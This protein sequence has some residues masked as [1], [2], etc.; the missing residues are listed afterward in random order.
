MTDNEINQVSVH[1]IKFSNLLPDTSYF[2]RVFSVAENG[3]EVVSSEFSFITSA[4]P[5]T[6]A[7][8]ILAGPDPTN[9]ETGSATIEW[10]TDELSTSIIEFGERV[11]AGLIQYTGIIWVEADAA[12][13]T[14][15]KV[16]LTGLTPGTEYDYRVTSVDFSPLLNEVISRN[17]RF[18]TSMFNDTIAPVL[19]SGPIV[20]KTDKTAIFEWGTDEASDSFVF[21]KRKDKDKNFRKIGDDRKVTNHVVTVTNLIKGENYEFE[22]ASRDLAGNLMT[23]PTVLNTNDMNKVLALRKTSQVPGGFGVFFTNQFPDTRVLIIIEGPSVVQ[24]TSETITIQW[25]TDERSDSFVD[26]GLDESFG[27]IKGEVF[28]VT[29]HRV[30]LTNLQSA[31]VYNF[32]VSS[33]D[34]SNNG[35][36]T[37]GTSAV[38]TES[39]ADESPPVITIGP[40]I[41]S[42]TNDQATVLWETDEPADSRL[43]FGFTSDYERVLLST[44]DKT[45][46]FVTLTNLLPDTLYHLR[47]LSTDISDNGLTASADTT[48]RTAATADVIPP[49]IDSIRVAAITD[50]SATIIFIT[51]ELGD[52]FIEF[53]F[54]TDS[55]SYNIGSA[56]DV[57]E[58]ELTLTNL[59]PDTT[60]HFGVGS[61]DKS[62][63]E[64]AVSTLKRGLRKMS[65]P[66]SPQGIIGVA[67]SEQALINWSPNNEDDLAGYNL[68]K[69]EN[70][71]PFQLIETLLTDTF[72]YDDIVSNNSVFWYKVTAADQ[73]VP[74]NESEDSENISVNPLSQFSVSVPDAVS[75]SENQ[76]IR[77]DEIIIKV[78]NISLPLTRTGPV[79]YDFVIAEEEDF[80]NQVISD[81]KVPAGDTETTW[82][83]GVTLNHNQTY[84]W[85]VRA[86]DGFFY[87][88]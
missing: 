85:K 71:D 83:P 73:V 45:F 51:D 17:K 34:P 38:S 61:I 19:I 6:I 58:H 10:T 69:R 57:I 76:S 11:Q 63:N 44:E 33:T 2:Y 74:F 21:I 66:A 4:A 70:S 3:A 49:L 15:H 9:V 40:V 7:P 48:F 54:S 77:N 72:Y 59:M 62:G 79:T 12:G 80:F 64:N 47:V 13:V 8:K 31:T 14:D 78:D 56:N 1:Q 75:P 22:L 81:I 42:I 50:K 37:S 43:E 65:A 24:K 30:T 25:K 84:F 32:K 20:E 36:S 53:W 87:G 67:G 29:D 26:F 68:Y 82:I 52:T 35:P 46:H 41:S 88:D 86:F 39:E 5:D 55:L 27:Q 18:T 28:D 16:I 60:Y 23:W